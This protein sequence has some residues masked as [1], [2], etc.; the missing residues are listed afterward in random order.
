MSFYIGDKV[1]FCK[2]NTLY[3][4]T[5]VDHAYNGKLN[6]MCTRR[7]VLSNGD[8]SK[9]YVVTMTVHQSDVYLVKSKGEK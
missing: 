2:Q 9:P 3:Y 1:R 8:L 6:V 4:G 5:I 7:D